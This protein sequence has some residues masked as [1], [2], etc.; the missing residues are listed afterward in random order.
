[1]EL[2]P[3]AS[4]EGLRDGDIGLISS[5]SKTLARH[6]FAVVTVNEPETHLLQT[7]LNFNRSFI[8]SLIPP[9]PVPLD[10]EHCAHGCDK[11]LMAVDLLALQERMHLKVRQLSGACQDCPY[12][13]STPSCLRLSNVDLVA[14]TNAAARDI[15]DEIAR[16]SL[17]SL[18]QYA[19]EIDIMRLHLSTYG[20]MDSFL[21]H[22]PHARPCPA[23]TD[24]GLLTLLINSEDGLQVLVRSDDASQETS[25]ESWMT[26]E[27]PPGHVVVMVSRALQNI[28]GDSVPACR[29]RVVP[30]PSLQ[31]LSIAYE[32][33]PN[34]LAVA[35]LHRRMRSN[36]LKQS[37]GDRL[38]SWLRLTSSKLLF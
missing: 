16:H 30:V 25:V 18:R 28:L 32:L 24:P 19:P 35:E 17:E 12:T 20:V 14:T 9:Y 22:T 34:E 13:T 5:F 10:H 31:R 2:G 36:L 38:R 8:N 26:L 15:F 11:D 37:A 23:H 6:G 21:Y 1:M 4:L 7:A 29:H 3:V 33:L 27:L